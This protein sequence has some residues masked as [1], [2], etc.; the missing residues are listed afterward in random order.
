M[1]QD[2]ACF[3]CFGCFCCFGCFLVVFVWFLGLFFGFVLFFFVC[4]VFNSV[5]NTLA[6]QSEARF[7]FL[8]KLPSKTA[9]YKIHYFHHYG[10]HHIL[11]IHSK[12]TLSEI[13]I[14][15]QLSPHSTTFFLYSSS[16]YLLFSYLYHFLPRSQGF[17]GPDLWSTYI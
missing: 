5:V 7:R 12:N 11:V 15:R 4:F 1:G 2:T 14:H 8:V 17:K 3:G 6:S 9:S 13:G 16:T 10:S